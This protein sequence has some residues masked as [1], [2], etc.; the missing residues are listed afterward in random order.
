MVAREIGLVFIDPWTQVFPATYDNYRELDVREVFTPLVKLMHRHEFATLVVA[1]F[2]KRDS[3]DFR[4]LVSGS[5]ALLQLCRV[6]LLVSLDPDQP[7]SP[8]PKDGTPRSRI[9]SIQNTR[10]SAGAVPQRFELSQ[11]SVRLENDLVP[12]KWPCA[13]SLE[14]APELAGQDLLNVLPAG[15][16]PKW[17]DRVEARARGDRHQAGAARRAR[18]T[19]RAGRRAL[20]RTGRDARGARGRRS[21]DDDAQAG[22]QAARGR[23]SDRAGRVRA[24]AGEG[25]RREMFCGWSKS[26]AQ[27]RDRPVLA[28]W[29][30]PGIGSSSWISRG[31]TK[32]R[33]HA[34]EHGFKTTTWRTR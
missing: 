32:P 14:P 34:C 29:L 22:V 30:A 19:A 23:G 24:V 2:N 18:G 31:Q 11:K 10:M 16:K 4:K 27:M 9:L 6:A 17:G 12:A 1:H 21:L 28:I 15:A 33:T 3:N 26:R 25:N 13:S 7:D 20:A 5:A 8:D